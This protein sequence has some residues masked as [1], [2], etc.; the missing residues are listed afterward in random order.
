MKMFWRQAARV[1]KFPKHVAAYPLPQRALPDHGAGLGCPIKR[2]ARFV[3][4]LGHHFG[5]RVCCRNR[6]V[7]HDDAARCL[8]P[9]GMGCRCCLSDWLQ[10]IGR[11]QACTVRG[12]EEG[13]SWTFSTISSPTFLTA[14][15][16]SDAQVAMRS[17]AAC[18]SAAIRSAACWVGLP[19]R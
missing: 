6:P 9:H 10:W 16:E 19:V 1:K 18:F 7:I 2:Q 15:S 4:S 11:H 5:H 17:S 3:P 8:A 12:N 13:I 14:V